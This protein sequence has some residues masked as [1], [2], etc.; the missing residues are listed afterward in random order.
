MEIQ[1]VERRLQNADA[2]GERPV[3]MLLRTEIDSPSIGPH[4]AAEH[5]T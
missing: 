3:T 1:D 5:M 2:D 4:I